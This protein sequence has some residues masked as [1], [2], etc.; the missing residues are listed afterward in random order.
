MGIKLHISGRIIFPGHGNKLDKLLQGK[1]MKNG[2]KEIRK[3]ERNIYVSLAW[4]NIYVS[5]ASGSTVFRVGSVD[6]APRQFSDPFVG[7]SFFNIHLMISILAFKDLKNKCLAKF[8]S[9][10]FYFRN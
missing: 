2:R 5:L 7:L 1:K 3:G 4:W 9:E 10:E 6:I 8:I